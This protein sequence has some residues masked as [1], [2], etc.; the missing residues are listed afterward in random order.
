MAEGRFREDLY[1][2]LHV[3]PIHV[4]PLRERREDVLA[5]ARHFARFYA[6]ENGLETPTLADTTEER[7]W[8]GTG[9]GTCASSRT[10]S[11][12]R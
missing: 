12:A 2:R 6:A 11:S 1:Y 3:L 8:P 7:L 9:R 4:P 5:L 10:R